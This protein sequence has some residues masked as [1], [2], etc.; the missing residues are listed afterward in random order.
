[1]PRKPEEQLPCHQPPVPVGNIDQTVMNL[2]PC[3]VAAMELFC[4]ASVNSMPCPE[5][6]RYARVSSTGLADFCGSDE[7]SSLYVPSRR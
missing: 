1:M 4:L 3:L 7:S 2:K 6:R 5:V